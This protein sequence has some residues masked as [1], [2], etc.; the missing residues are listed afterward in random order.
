MGEAVERRRKVLRDEVE[1]W[2]NWGKSDKSLNRH[3]LYPLLT[4]LYCDGQGTFGKIQDQE[5]CLSM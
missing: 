3:H 2:E 5:H 1:A 4:A